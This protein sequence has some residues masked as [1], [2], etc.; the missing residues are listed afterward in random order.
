MKTALA[1]ATKASDV[2]ESFHYRNVN[3]LILVTELKKMNSVLNWSKIARKYMSVIFFKNHE[4]CHLHHKFVTPQG[5]I[6]Y[7]LLVFQ[8]DTHGCHL[9]ESHSNPWFLYLTIYFDSRDTFSLKYRRLRSNS[10]ATENHGSNRIYQ[11]DEIFE[12]SFTFSLK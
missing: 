11:G 6:T 1:A 5:D 12:G 10:K 3:K 7:F 8:R 2:I 9:V 4:M